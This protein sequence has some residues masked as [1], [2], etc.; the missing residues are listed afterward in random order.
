V[1]SP[2]A[3]LRLLR[4]QDF[5]GEGVAALH[6]LFNR[7]IM[8]GGTIGFLKPMTRKAAREYFD[9][10]KM[11]IENGDV[12]A[13]VSGSRPLDGF[14]LI[15]RD[16]SEL[17]RHC[18]EM[19][20]VMVRHEVQRHGLG[21]AIVRRLVAE[22]KR[23]KVEILWLDV[24]ITNVPAIQLFQKLGFRTWGIFPDCIKDRRLYVDVLYMA[25]DLRP[26]YRPQRDLP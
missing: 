12:I 11:G 25:L 19:G 1:P 16:P 2:R 14:G 26:T 8:H 10:L 22:A 6:T 21:A 9:T 18:W 13:V 7:S 23:R 4:P 20:R 3:N 5:L 24:R 15:R 17:R